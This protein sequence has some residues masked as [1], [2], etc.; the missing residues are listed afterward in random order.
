M[1]YNQKCKRSDSP[2]TREPFARVKYTIS[3]WVDGSKRSFHEHELL[4]KKSFDSSRRQA[5]SEAR[6]HGVTKWK[7]STIEGQESSEEPKLK[8]NIDNRECKSS[9][10]Q[11]FFRLD[12]ELQ[13]RVK[14]KSDDSKAVEWKVKEG[15]GKY[16]SHKGPGAR[17]E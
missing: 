17:V 6:W 2:K 15:Y 11:F 14:A 13:I 5:T 10:N 8:I 4:V 1:F 12:Y 9:V 16:W 7:T 3:V